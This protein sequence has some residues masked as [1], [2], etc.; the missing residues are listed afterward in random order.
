M[1]SSVFSS[2]CDAFQSVDNSETNASKIS[3]NVYKKNKTCKIVTSPKASLKYLN[4]NKT[5]KSPEDSVR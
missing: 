1:S 2:C 3:R 4:N 5:I